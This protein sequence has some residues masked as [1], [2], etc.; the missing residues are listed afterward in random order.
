[1][2][3]ID[4]FA[5]IGGVRLGLEQAGHVC[6]GWCEFD[7]FAQKTYRAIH[8]PVKEEWF[9]DDVRTVKPYDVPQADGWCFG[10]PCQD[11]S[12]AGNQRGLQGG[13]RSGLFY[14]IMR[15]LAGREER[16]RPDWLLVENV[17]ALLSIGNGF[18]F[19]RVLS[20]MA[21][22]G[23]VCEW[24]LLNSKDFGVPQ[25][26]ERVFVVGHL[27]G[28]RARKIFPIQ[29]DTGEN[30]TTLNTV[31]VMRRSQGYR[32]FTPDGLA[33]TQTS[34]GGGLGAKTGLYA[35][36][37][38]SPSRGEGR[39]N[40]LYLQANEEG[41]ASTLTSS[42]CGDYTSDYTNGV[43]VAPVL[44][45]DR[46][47]KRQNGRRVKDYG[48]P[49]FTLTTQD[50][51]GVALKDDETIRVRRLTPRKC[52]RLQG[53]PDEYFDRAVSAGISDSQLY[54]QAGN[55]VTVNVAKAI[56]EKL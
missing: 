52:W 44:T 54:K 13:K 33:C 46:L 39:S 35:V 14:E 56:G 27:R 2:L 26:R 43:L 38:R 3:F 7:K 31:S 41:V 25:N 48:E 20:E 36:K 10:F 22:V 55:A 28:R 49:S 32:T 6:A 24:Q 19:L 34:L 23:Y 11:I 42:H 50:K 12:V 8:S 18:D 51:H 29:G 1:M 15:L 21:K 47:T 53:F 45:P 16:D 4:F 40:S 17:K 9:A 37:F 5:G 30:T